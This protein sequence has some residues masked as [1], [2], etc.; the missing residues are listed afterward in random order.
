MNGSKLL[1][2]KFYI[3]KI[4]LD[5]LRRIG[6]HFDSS[7][8][9]DTDYYTYVFPAYKYRNAV[10]LNCT[11]KINTLNGR[12]QIDVHDSNGLY[13]PW[14]HY[15][16]G[17]YEPLIRKIDRTIKQKLKKIGIEEIGRKKKEQNKTTTHILTKKR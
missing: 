11:L 6:F 10:I 3:K 4:D 9:E 13:A 12:V 7:I 14:Y 1:N 15:E 5:F 16:Y 8:S 17:N 2:K